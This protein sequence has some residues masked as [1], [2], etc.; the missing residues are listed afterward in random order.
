MSQHHQAILNVLRI[1]D[2]HI[3]VCHTQGVLV[4]F[5]RDSDV[6]VKAT[7][8]QQEAYIQASYLMLR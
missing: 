7:P 6:P 1:G 4:T 3:G 2:T 5:N 8:G